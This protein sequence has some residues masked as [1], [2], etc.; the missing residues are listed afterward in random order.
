MKKNYF[1]VLLFIAGISVV[2]AQNDSTA[3]NRIEFKLGLNY[4]SGFNYY[5]RTDSLKSSG[6]FPLAE[7]WFSP[8][9]YVNAAPVFIN[10]QV[11]KL[12]Y[13]GTITTLGFQHISK[14]WFTNIY[15]SKPFY[16]Q[17]SQLVQSALKGQA[18]INLSYLTSI[19]NIT[20]GADIKYSNKADYGATSGI[21]HIFR[22]QNNDNSVIVID[23]TFTIYSGTQNFTNSYYEKKPGFLLLPG[24]SSQ[25]NKNEQRFDL[26]AYEF[27]IPF[28]YSMGKWQL[29]ITPAYIVPKN[30][31]TIPDH[32]ELSEKGE[33]MFYG[34]AGIKRSF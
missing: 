26:L 16:K 34:T 30:L 32:P 3:P 24:T 29:L 19:L 23:P 7:I 8:H 4:N 12:Q 14:K 25:V 11:E 21:D 9:L 22:I 5:G 15:L 1:I 18:G 6:F 27:S 13:A 33:P 20:G 17:S 2:N 28:I 10:N 31:I